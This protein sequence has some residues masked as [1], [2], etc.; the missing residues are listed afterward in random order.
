[1]DKVT[2]QDMTKAL[3]GVAR[4]KIAKQCE[5]CGAEL[6]QASFCSN[7]QTIYFPGYKPC[8]CEQAKAQAILEKEE[9]RKIISLE[10]HRKKEER[11]KE[12][13]KQLFGHS[14][15]SKR[16]LECSLDK[17]QITFENAEAVRICNEYINDFDIISRSNRN[18]LY[19]TGPCGVGKSHLAFSIA[20]TLIEKGNSVIAMT[21]IDLLMKIRGS[22]ND[23][24]QKEEE[25][26]K[27]YEDC[28]LLVIDDLG[29]EKPTGWAL[30]MI[31]SIIDHRYN[32]KKPMIVTTNFNANEL[33][34]VFGNS[35]I[36]QAIM[37]RLFEICRYVPI[38]GE[39]FRRK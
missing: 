3:D 35:S 5:Y 30:Q 26:L 29:K 13:I 11:R 36:S 12:R 16:A 10:E 17:Y 9:K 6:E 20:N 14:G 4:G 27:I 28:A 1:M 37:D 25:I 2:S 19:I 22:Y 21:M 32:A 8:N 33:M 18:G 34:E 15:M 39:S 38:E 31:Y 23:E 7:G 24:H